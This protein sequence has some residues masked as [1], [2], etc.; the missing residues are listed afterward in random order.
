MDA[1]ESL[2]EDI[3]AQD[4]EEVLTNPLLIRMLEMLR[5]EQKEEENKP[6]RQQ[7]LKVAKEAV[8]SEAAK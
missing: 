1:I 7:Q 2:D 8:T 5:E 4:M 6:S 3:S